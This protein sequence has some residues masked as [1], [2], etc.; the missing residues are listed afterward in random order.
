[1]GSGILAAALFDFSQELI[2]K[3]EAIPIPLST[4]FIDTLRCAK[5]HPHI[6]ACKFRYTERVSAG[7]LYYKVLNSKQ[8]SCPFLEFTLKTVIFKTVYL[9]A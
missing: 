2:F 7:G 1:M 6:W 4:T 3:D 5:H 9:Y 8:N